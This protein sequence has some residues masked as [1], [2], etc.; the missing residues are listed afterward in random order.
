[1]MFMKVSPNNK[2]KE[3]NGFRHHLFQM[4]EPP[5]VDRDA[6]NRYYEFVRS[7]RSVRSFS[8]RPIP[9]SLIEEIVFT[10]SSAPSGANKQPYTFC[11]VSDPEI[12]RKI[13]EAAEQEEKRNYQERMNKEW[14]DDLQQFDTNWEKP[15]LEIAPWLIIV[16]KQ[17]Y[18]VEGQEKVQHY[19]V[20]ESTGL[21]CGFL[22][23]AIHCAG[24]VALTHTPSPM[25]FLSE[26]LDQ[27]VNCKPFLLIPVGYPA[28][29]TYVPEI[30]RK[31][32]SE[33][34]RFY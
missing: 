26:I 33:I 5:F 4:P 17:I 24:L 29:E 6:L 10:A 14:L 28:E 11:C 8:S 3:I 31:N 20:N 16:F 1:M 19:Y 34:A 13:R 25:N 18:G 27:P 21:A 15:F 23:N 22:L 7:R 9:K 30:R 2:V 12:K 32:L